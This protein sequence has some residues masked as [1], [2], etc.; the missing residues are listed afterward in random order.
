MRIFNGTKKALTLPYTGGETLTI[1]AHQPSGNVLCSPE[2]LSSVITAYNADEIAVIASG[3]FEISACANIPTAVNYVVQSLDEAIARFNPDAKAKLAAEKANEQEIEKAKA[4]EEPK[5]EPKPEP[6]VE[7]K[8]VEEP[9]KEEPKAE[10]PKKPEL[11]PETVKKAK[12]EQPKSTEEID[13]EK[14]AE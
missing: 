11:K 12:K 1:P 8:P 13:G 4:K 10:E 7:E 2:F 5:P 3:P 6:K 9:K 14:K